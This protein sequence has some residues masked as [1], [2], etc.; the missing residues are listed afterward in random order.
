MIYM[1]FCYL[2]SV[3]ENEAFVYLKEREKYLCL[4]CGAWYIAFQKLDKF[5]KVYQKILKKHLF[6][7][8]LINDINTIEND[9]YWRK[10]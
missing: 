1:V 9:K 10:K 3:E 6:Y 8:N 5:L 2:C 4:E 7:F